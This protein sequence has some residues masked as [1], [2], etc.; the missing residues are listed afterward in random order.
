MPLEAPVTRA[1]E[2]EREP[3]SSMALSLPGSRPAQ[4]TP[5]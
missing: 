4:T 5:R 3:F 1:R 2:R